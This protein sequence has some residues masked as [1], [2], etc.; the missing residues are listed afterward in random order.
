MSRPIILTCAVTGGT[1]MTKNSRY[2][3][4]TPEQIATECIAAAS[5]GA[6]CVHIHVRDPATGAPEMKFEYYEEV[7][8]RI[9]NSDVDVVLNLTTGMG[10]NYIPSLE[11]GMP[12]QEVV[13]HPVLRTNHISKLKPEVCTLDVATMNFGEKAIVNTPDHLRMM[14]KMISEAGTKPELEVFD[15]GQLELALRLIDEG[16]IEK[17]PFFQFCLGIPGGAPATTEAMIL[18]KS[19]VPPGAVW[20]A[21]GIGRTQMAMVAQSAILGGH[22]R[23][24]L[25][26]NL[27]IAHGELAEGNVPLVKRGVQIIEGLGFELATPA[28]ARQIL[29]LS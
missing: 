22:C 10:A 25:E 26:D 20:S 23:V 2:V 24:G 28:Q 1:P 4:I 12:A 29:S 13:M 14:A 27:F 6:A 8:D 17:P 3:P 21:F 16:Q 15:L 19:M 7:V 18:M 9:R 11:E 5:A